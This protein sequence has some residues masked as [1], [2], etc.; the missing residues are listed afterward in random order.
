[1][2][3]IYTNDQAYQAILQL[4]P[5]NK[6][7]LDYVKNQIKKRKNVFISEENVVKTGVDLKLSDQRFTRALGKK[8]KKVF[9]GE[10]KESRKLFSYNRVTSKNVYRVTVCFRLKEDDHS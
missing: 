2:N 4:R 8:L 9:N 1:M 6:E 10:V 7:V 5:Y 3:E